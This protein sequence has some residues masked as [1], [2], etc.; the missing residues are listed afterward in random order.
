MSRL[1]LPCIDLRVPGDEAQDPLPEPS[2]TF[3]TLAQEATQDSVG[4]LVQPIAKRVSSMRY[5]R[6]GASRIDEPL[7]ADI[8]SVGPEYG[9]PVRSK[10]ARATRVVSPMLKHSPVD[11][12]YLRN[13]QYE[14]LICCSDC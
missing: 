5:I 8:G 11:D 4:A 12:R 3:R 2:A 14:P 13:P 9:L 7:P 10:R 6:T 1:R